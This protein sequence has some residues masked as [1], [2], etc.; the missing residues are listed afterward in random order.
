MWTSGDWTIEFLAIPRSRGGG[1]GPTIGLHAPVASWSDPGPVRERIRDKATAYG[2]VGGP[3][4][5]AILVPGLH[6][7][8]QSIAAVLYGDLAVE[9]DPANVNSPG[10]R[11]RK[12]NGAWYAGS[13]WRHTN[14]SAALVIRDLH[15]W[16]LTTVIPT[17]WHHPA[18]D[19][20]AGAIAP[21]F[22]QARPND[23]TGRIDFVEPTMTSAYFFDLRDDWP[24]PEP[25]FPT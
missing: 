13:R 5:V 11:V 18:A 8:D 24:G 15:P 14:V 23:T 3:F 1:A 4:I 25:G 12:P 17:L 9:P 22:R 7:D 2:D 21:I 6:A 19:K 20:P 10:R 16:N